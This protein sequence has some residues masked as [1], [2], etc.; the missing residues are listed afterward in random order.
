MTTQPIKVGLVGAGRIGRNHAEILAR[1]TPGARLV[2]VADPHRPAAEALA[3]E[4]DV[5]VV[6]ESM[7][8]L[9]TQDIQAVTIAAPS[10]LHSQLIQQAAAAG[11]AIFCEK[12]ASMDLDELDAALAAVE[13]AGVVFQV[14]FNRRFAPGFAAA[15]TAI[16]NGRLGA[17]QL[18]RSNTRDPK[19]ADPAGPPP[20]TIFTQTLIHDF[21]TLNWLN[22]GAEPVRVYAQADALI[23]PDFK[24]KGLLDTALVT[25]AYSNG[26]LAMADASFQ[27]VYGYDV[28]GEVFG[29][30]GM[31]TAGHARVSD[32]TL[33]GPSGAEVSTSRSDTELLQDSYRAEFAA[34]IEAVRTGVVT[35]ATGRDARRALAIAMAAIESYDTGLPVQL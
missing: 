17:V 20:F 12:P 23:A 11:K 33:Y 4:L 30:G 31:A 25:I 9:L 6:C 7:D 2:A 14:G 34:F 1:H 29:S 22:P 10:F 15:R 3:A 16:D 13:Q 35:G 27:A 21:D 5:P 24:D 28:R 18:L 26:A 32:M 8:E 19:L